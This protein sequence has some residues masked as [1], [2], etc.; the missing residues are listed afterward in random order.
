MCNVRRLTHQS[1]VLDMILLSFFW[2]V[3]FQFHLPDIPSES[4]A[5]HHVPW[6]DGAN[7]VWLCPHRQEPARGP[8]ANIPLGG[9]TSTANSH[10]LIVRDGYHISSRLG[11]G[12]WGSLFLLQFDF[13]RAQRCHADQWDGHWEPDWKTLN[14]HI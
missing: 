12:S 1:L 14:L 9:A 8:E 11:G 10:P 13:S 4:F 6:L 3:T 2:S 5:S 7:R